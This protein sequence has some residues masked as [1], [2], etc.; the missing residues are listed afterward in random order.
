MYILYVLGVGYV[1][2]AHRI[3]IK[4]IHIYIYIDTIQY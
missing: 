4:Y 3:C 2:Y 1:L